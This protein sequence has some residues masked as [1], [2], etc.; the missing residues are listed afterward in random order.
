MSK[1]FFD[2]EHLDTID[3]TW[4]D[5]MYAGLVELKLRIE[6]GLNGNLNEK[7]KNPM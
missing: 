5:T 6:I 1:T 4:I 2:D 7:I 3:G